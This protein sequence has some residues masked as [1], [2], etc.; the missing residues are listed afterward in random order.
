MQ[1]SFFRLLL[2]QINLYRIGFKKIRFLPC[3]NGAPK[4]L[5]G[6]FFLFFQMQELSNGMR[7]HLFRLA[8]T[9]FQLSNTNHRH[10]PGNTACV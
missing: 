7:Q 3:V 10:V 6:E 4:H 5:I 1:D 9:Q 2:F 8:R